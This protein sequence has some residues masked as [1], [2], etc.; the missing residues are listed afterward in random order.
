MNRPGIDRGN[1]RS[2]WR[3][4]ALDAR[5]SPTAC[6]RCCVTYDRVRAAAVKRHLITPRAPAGADRRRTRIGT[7]TRSSTSCACARSS[8]ATATASATSAGWH[9]SST[10]CRTS[11]SRRS[12]CCR[13]TPRRCATTATTSPTTPTSTPTS[14]RSTTSSS[15]S[16]RRTARG[17]RV[18]TELVLNH[19]S[20]QHPWFQ[21]ARRAPAGSVERDFYVW[22]DTPERY[23]RG[24]HHLQG[25][26][27][28][29]LGAG[30]RSRA[31]TSGT[32][33]TRTSPT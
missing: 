25:L 27:A 12:G 18:I 15:S 2:G 13:S 28:V 29:E 31:P 30:I 1:W 14:A 3:A 17:I 32:A 24:A 10:T 8:T 21:R 22:S 33:S 11:A 9:R 6:A 4:G 19:T 23:R 20:D 16:T 7:R 5:R 26:R